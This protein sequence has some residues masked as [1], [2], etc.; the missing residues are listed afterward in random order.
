MKH[1]SIASVLRFR[2]R[3]IL[4]KSYTLI[5]NI[6]WYIHVTVAI[7][8]RHQQIYECYIVYW[9]CTLCGRVGAGNAS[10]RMKNDERTTV[11]VNCSEC[12][13]HTTCMVATSVRMNSGHLFMKSQRYLTRRQYVSKKYLYLKIWIKTLVYRV[14][15]DRPETEL[16]C[17]G[18]LIKHTL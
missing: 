14:C 1:N 17:S 3:K 8:L 11:P 15:T 9:R 13:K 12:R 5:P 6:H 16:T 2:N 10:F 7:K 4:I 18:R